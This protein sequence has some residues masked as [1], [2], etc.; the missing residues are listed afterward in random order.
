MFIDGLPEK[1]LNGNQL[2]DAI[3]I[4]SPR[5]IFL[6]M[7]HMVWTLNGRVF[8]MNAIADDEKIPLEQWEVWEYVNQTMIAHPMHIH[9]VQFN[10]IERQSYMAGSANY[11]TLVSGMVDDGWKDTVLVMPGERVRLLVKFL[12][13][14]G[15]FMYHCHILEHEGMGMMRNLMVGDNPDS[16]NMPT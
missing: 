14:G 12:T 9:N 2:K 6:G 16:M 13:Y 8:D 11:D 4:N 15:M 10:V 7:Q 5:T 3:N 1:P